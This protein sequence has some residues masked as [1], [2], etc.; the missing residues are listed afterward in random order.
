MKAEAKLSRFERVLMNVN[1]QRYNFLEGEDFYYSKDDE[2]CYRLS[3]QKL[4]LGTFAVFA[5]VIAVII[6]M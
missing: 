6:C 3:I 5:G 2:A 4:R 1:S